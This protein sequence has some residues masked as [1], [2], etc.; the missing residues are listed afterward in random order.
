[1]NR[2]ISPNWHV[3]FVHYPI[4]FLS[5]GILI[6][7]LSIP[8]PRGLLRGAGRW[9]I[10]LGTLLAI[11][12]LTVGMYALATV[13]GPGHSWYEVTK[14]SHWS[15][16]QWQ[17]MRC[18]IWLNSIGVVLAAGAVTIW[19]ACSDNWR[20]R[21]YWPVLLVLIAAMG[22]LAAGAWFGGESVYRYG[23]AVASASSASAAAEPHHRGVTWYIPPLELHVALA[24]L[25]VAI[26]VAAI[27]LTIRRLEAPSTVPEPPE[28]IAPGQPTAEE[29]PDHGALAAAPVPSVV[30]DEA[31]P[32]FPARFW[33]AAAAVALCTAVAGLWSVLGVFSAASLKENGAMLRRND[34]DHLRLPLH[35]VFGV[36]LVVLTLLLAALARFGRRRRK[37][38]VG[39]L[40]LI[41]LVIAAQFWLGLALLYD[42]HTGPVLGFKSA[43]SAH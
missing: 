36:T 42:G 32:V 30:P 11:P 9:M 26:A 4:A 43:T 17:Y 40:A 21:L 31:R 22:L 27:G 38:T 13:V 1:M 15:S 12:T 41:I 6:E 16:D 5:G 3:V 2:F 39:F 19:L 34:W 25:T 29:P 18:H 24:G 14:D 20:R 10:L 35:V 7:L 37:L 28:T 23:T 33:L 8:W